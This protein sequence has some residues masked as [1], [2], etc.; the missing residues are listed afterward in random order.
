MPSLIISSGSINPLAPSREAGAASPASPAAPPALVIGERLEAIVTGRYPEQ[1]VRL[2]L[3]AATVTARSQVPLALGEKLTVQVE[4]LSPGVVLRIC[5]RAAEEL[6]RFG[7]AL[8]AC[9]ANPDALKGL[10]I[11]AR[12]IFAAENLESLPAFLPKR[13]L[14]RVVRLLERIVLSKENI[15]RPLCLRESL[16]ALGLDFERGL[17]RAPGEGAGA[18]GEASEPSLKET[19]LQ[20]SAEWPVPGA[21]AETGGTGAPLKGF[22]DQALRVIESLQLVN[23]LAQEQERL[24][25]LQIPLQGADGLRMQELFIARDGGGEGEGEGPGCR[26][27][28]FVDLDALGALAVEA[29]LRQGRLDGTLRSP[30]QAV[31]DHLSPLLPELEAQLAQLGYPTAV[32]RCARVADLPAFRREFMMRYRLYSQ[33]TIDVS[34]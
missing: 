20:W 7:D 23:V 25:V 29:N 11:E 10:L 9:R 4:R 3:A 22:I 24:T 33:S 30:H 14:Q 8:K 26:A 12:A 31:L 6:L 15:G 18:Q 28:L 16:T 2:Q 13:E 27:L 5:D 17:L 19:L 32:V 1:R 21:P 34:A